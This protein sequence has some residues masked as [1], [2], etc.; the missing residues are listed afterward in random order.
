MQWLKTVLD[1][2][3]IETWKNKLDVIWLQC[4]TDI[5]QTEKRLNLMTNTKT[6]LYLWFQCRNAISQLNG[7]QQYW[8]IT[9]IN[10]HLICMKY[11]W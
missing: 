7:A 10:L 3:L 5:F 2:W 8:P 4:K 1:L 11:G 6:N 9:K